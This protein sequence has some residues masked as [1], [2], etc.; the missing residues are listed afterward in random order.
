MARRGPNEGSIHQRNDGYWAATVDLGF[1]NGKRKR[2]Y[3]YGKTRREVAEKLKV[4]LREQQQ[5][6]PIAIERQ[7]VEQFLTK[8]LEDTA[9]PTLRPSTYTGYEV[10]VRVHIIP[11]LGRIQLQQLSP[12]HVQAFLKQKRESGLANRTVQY[13]HAVLRRALGQ[14]V[15]WGAVPRNVATLV[16]PPRVQHTEVQPWTP[17]QARTFL[18]AMQGDRLAALYSVALALGLRRGEALGLRWDAVDFDKGILTVKAALQRVGGELQLLETKTNRSRRV[19]SLPQITIAALRSH[20]VRQV[21]ERLKAGA[22]WQEYGYV[23]TT[24]V[25]TPIEPRNINRSFEA[26]IRR[27]AVPRIRFHDMRHTCASL[28]LAQGVHPRVVMD[29]LGHSKISVTMDTYSHVT[30]T[31]QREAATSMDTI[32]DVKAKG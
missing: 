25:G 16:D 4:A 14:A 32:L 24:K 27:A 13:M 10:L 5:G 19:I 11:A 15:K 6:L 22:L 28:L 23:F 26:A 9:K 2:K 7:T 29:V 21:E 12:Q 3:F 20:R 8:W 17:E 31:L 30:S 1:V 18:E